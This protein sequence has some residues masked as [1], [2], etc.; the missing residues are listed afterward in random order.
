MSILAVAVA[1]DKPTQQVKRA[2]I[3]SSGLIFDV[4]ALMYDVSNGVY[5]AVFE[6]HVIKH[7]P[8]ARAVY[9]SM[10]AQVVKNAQPVK[11]MLDDGL[12]KALSK[13]DMRKED[14]MQ[15][16]ET[17]K[18][19]KTILHEEMALRLSTVRGKLDAITAR[20]VAEFDAA[21]PRHAGA[22]PDTFGDFLIF[23][24]YIAFLCYIV[25]RI[26]HTVQRVLRKCF[27]IALGLFC[28]IC[29]CGCICRGKKGT[30]KVSEAAKPKAT[31]G[32][33]EKK[34]KKK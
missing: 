13:M 29:C 17:I 5:S 20:Y 8:K 11:A 6:Q 22:L 10:G 7:G 15:K 28:N 4:A 31:A 23:V 2:P 16:Y 26:L 33:S 9:D 18:T 14:V 32:K 24:V 1:Q 34:T 25:Q 21:M 30:T 3:V 12:E 19:K 27:E